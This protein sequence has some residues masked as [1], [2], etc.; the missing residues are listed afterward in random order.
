[1]TLRRPN[2]YLVWGPLI[3]VFVLWFRVAR[4]QDHSAFVAAIV[5][6]EPFHVLAHSV[7]YGT[8]AW[9]VIRRFGDRIAWVLG[10]VL[11]MGLVQEL[12]QVVGVRA[13]G[14]PELFDLAVDATAA[15]GVLTARRIARVLAHRRSAPGEARSDATRGTKAPS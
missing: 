10:I 15:L 13:F 3:T 11:A 6:S 4:P 5:A 1:M 7:L 14:G 12:A 2:A 8:L 9:L